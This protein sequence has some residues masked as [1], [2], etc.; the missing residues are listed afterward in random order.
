LIGTTASPV[1]AKLGALANNGGQTLTHALLSG[2]PAIEAGVVAVAGANGIPL[3]DQRG[4]PFSRVVNYDNAGGAR[5]DIGAVEMVAPGPALPGDYNLNQSV[6]AGDYVLWR[7]TTGGSVTQAYAGADG[8]GNTV[9]NEGDYAVWRS[10]FGSTSGTGEGG[11]AVSA[12]Q[13]SA[14]S[15]IAMESESD[16][17][18]TLLWPLP[19]GEGASEDVPRT[20][21]DESL[22]TMMN[23]ADEA[24][25]LLMEAAGSKVN[26][27]VV[28]NTFSSSKEVDGALDVV[29][30]ALACDWERV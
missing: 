30:R 18:R 29:A 8:D 2:S 20:V 7:K 27:F 16:D 23:G 22:E 11:A 9:I 19:M 5:V 25:L 10:Y 15:G 17:A 12:A 28:A 4:T 1:D 3:F 14:V 21:G 24:L 6:D 13:T 26:G